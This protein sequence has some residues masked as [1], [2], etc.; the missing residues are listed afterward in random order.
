MAG[1]KDITARGKTV[2][3]RKQTL[4]SASMC[5]E[6]CLVVCIRWQTVST[7]SPFL[8]LDKN[9]RGWVRVVILILNQNK[10]G[11]KRVSQDILPPRS[12]SFWLPNF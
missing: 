6:L 10:A 3:D 8:I 7:V 11:S 4:L 5:Q 12:V 2:K 1:S 9:P